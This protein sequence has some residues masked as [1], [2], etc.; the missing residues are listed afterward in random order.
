MQKYYFPADIRRADVIASE[1]HGVPSVVLME[2]AS[3]NAS[4]EAFAM[5]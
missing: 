4:D 5:A 3:K 1:E 2:N